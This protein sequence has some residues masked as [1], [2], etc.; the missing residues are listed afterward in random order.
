MSKKKSALDFDH[1]SFSVVQLDIDQGTSGI[2]SQR[3][4]QAVTRDGVTKAYV[5]ESSYFR[6]E[7]FQF[8][9]R[10][11][12]SSYEQSIMKQQPALGSV[13]GGRH[14]VHL[15]DDTVNGKP[16]KRVSPEKFE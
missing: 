12:E 11:I 6:G 4:L 2:A 5:T 8:L 13:D 1:V 14:W 3:I 9:A 10:F 15:N 16:Q 7:M